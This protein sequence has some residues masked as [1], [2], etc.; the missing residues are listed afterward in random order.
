MVMERLLYAA[1]LW[2]PTP[3]LPVP[4]AAHPPQAAWELPGGEYSYAQLEIRDVVCWDSMEMP[5]HEQ[6]F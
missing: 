4:L 2:W 5:H 6:E 1:Q 3:C